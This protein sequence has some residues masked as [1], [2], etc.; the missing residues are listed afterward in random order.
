MITSIA[1]RN[2]WRNKKRSAIIIM[3]VAFGLWAGL[4]MIALALGMT[5][6]IVNS[7]IKSR[8]SHIQIHAQ[9]FRDHPETDLVIPSAD[10]AAAKCANLEYVEAVTGRAVIRGIAQSPT[11]NL[12]VIVYGVEPDMEKNVTDIDSSMI[13]GGYFQRDVRNPIVIGEKLAEKLGVGIGKKIVI[14]AQNTDGSIA[15]GAFRII[16]IYKTSYVQF[17]K[18]TVFAKHEDIS[19][20]FGLNGDFHEIA[21]TVSNVDMIPEVLSSL[22]NNYP[23]LETVSWKKI[24]PQV[25]LLVDTQYQ[26]MMIFMII[27]LLAL[28]FGITNTMLMGVLE[29]VRELGVVIA[30]GMKHG[31]IFVMILLETIFLSMLGGV[32]GMVMTVVTMEAV[33]RTGIDL[34]IV[35]KGLETFGMDSILYPYLPSD[36]YLIVGI[37]VFITSVVSSIY[38]GIKAVRLDPVGAIRSY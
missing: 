5:R 4:M 29:R 32:V 22:E 24:E 9:G 7:A 11:S 27:I 21:I 26:Y 12:G 2:V 38:P 35:S 17:D 33:S 23:N 1:W 13:E 6:Q 19:R 8:T 10:S 31:K 25:A 16:G 18:M 15:G 37:L 34:S 36:Q 14:N 3:A 20:I 28:V 30:L